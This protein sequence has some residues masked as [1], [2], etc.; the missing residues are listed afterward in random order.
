MKKNVK[1][2]INRVNA[3]GICLKRKDAPILAKIFAFL[4]IAY[5]LSPIDIIPDFIPIVGYL[6]DLIIVPIL[7]IITIKLLPK[8]MYAESL[9]E[10]EVMDTKA[11]KKKN[12]AG[13]FIISF[14]IILLL[15]IAVFLLKI[16]KI[17]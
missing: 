7:L 15:M 1:R 4:T 6:D 5:A 8:K 3:V 2:Y 16:L 10:A 11:L 14:N 17:I 9:R 12:W 13:I